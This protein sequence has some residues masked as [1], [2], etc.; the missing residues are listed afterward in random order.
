MEATFTPGQVADYLKNREPEIMAG[1]EKDPLKH[2]TQAM[3]NAPKQE[4]KHRRG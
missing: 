3:K 4:Q 2:L 1:V